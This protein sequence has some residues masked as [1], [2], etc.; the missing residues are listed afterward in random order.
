MGKNNTSSPDSMDRRSALRTIGTA[1]VGLLG[2]STLS[3][4]ATAKY[5]APSGDDTFQEHGG[6]RRTKFHNNGKVI[7]EFHSNISGP[8]NVGTDNEVQMAPYLAHTTRDDP[9]DKKSWVLT[10]PRLTFKTVS[11]PSGGDV[12]I[13]NIATYLQNNSGF[14][15]D[16]LKYAANAIWSLAQLPGPNPLSLAIDNGPSVSRSQDQEKVTIDYTH[17]GGRTQSA[18]WLANFGGQYPRGTYKFKM[19]AKIDWGYWE[20][21]RMGTEYHYVKTAK[22]EHP[23]S[24]TIS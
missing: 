13:T 6:E 8:T 4:G 5:I 2:A 21:K 3:G 23:F 15:K 20:K 10:R 11:E 9:F 1:S 19:T 18:W 14:P 12:Y 16:V 24:I 7:G 17:Q 22:N